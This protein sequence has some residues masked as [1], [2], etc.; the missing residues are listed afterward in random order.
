MINRPTPRIRSKSGSGTS[1]CCCLAWFLCQLTTVQIEFVELVSEINQSDWGMSF[2][3][4]MSKISL[5]D[6]HNCDGFA[7][8]PDQGQVCAAAS[9]GASI[10]EHLI[11]T[12]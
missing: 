8:N 9:Q 1:L 5:N 10:C 2:K 12:P 6:A 4:Y 7:E 11:Y 3:I